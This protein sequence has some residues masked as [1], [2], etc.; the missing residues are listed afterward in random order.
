[1]S[2]FPSRI[3]LILPFASAP[4]PVFCHIDAGIRIHSL[5]QW[6]SPATVPHFPALCSKLP[7][8]GGSLSRPSLPGSTLA[9]NPAGLRGLRIGLF[10]L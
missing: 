2:S 1:M 5:A 9:L 4:V 6:H 10:L 3:P 7:P 8:D